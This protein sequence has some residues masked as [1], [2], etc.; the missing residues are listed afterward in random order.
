MGQTIVCPTTIANPTFFLRL[1]ALPAPEL[2]QITPRLIG[3]W[4]PI[5]FIAGHPAIPVH[6]MEVARSLA[7]FTTIPG[8]M[9]WTP[10]IIGRLADGTRQFRPAFFQQFLNQSFNIPFGVVGKPSS[11]IPCTH[12]GI[13]CC[14]PAAKHTAGITPAPIVFH[15]HFSSFR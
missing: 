5:G 15:I 6:R 11:R 13:I 14:M 2:F 3:I 1:L 12:A 7:T 4:P 9:A 10:G 8:P